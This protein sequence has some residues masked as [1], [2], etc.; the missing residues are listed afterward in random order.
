MLGVKLLKAIIKGYYSV[1]IIHMNQETCW[2]LCWW[3]KT[4]LTL[5]TTVAN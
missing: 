2:W 5:P 4:N 1:R 3:N